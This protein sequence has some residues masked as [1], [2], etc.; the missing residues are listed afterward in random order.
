MDRNDQ[1]VKGS[2]VVPRE[3][4]STQ[5][6]DY[7]SNA[8]RGT[9]Y[10]LELELDWLATERLS[11][12]ANIGLL[13][14]SFDRYIRADGEDLAGHEQAHA[15]SYQIATGGRLNF[16]DHLYLR[17]DVEAK[18]SFFFSDR[19][20]LRANAHTLLHLRLGYQ[21]E[22]WEV[23]LWARNLTDRNYTTRGFGSFGNDPRKGY[24]V[25]PYTQLGEPRV[26][27]VSASYRFQ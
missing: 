5:F 18:D 26:V 1:Q 12:Y 10:G 23:A 4:E 14:A 9:N 13:D 21:R 11:L 22:T 27:G 25:E 15:P 8:A 20:E 3:D 19:H 7:T 6:I 16:S 2:L 17:A 24:V